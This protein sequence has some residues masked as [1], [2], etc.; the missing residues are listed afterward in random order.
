M[1]AYSTFIQRKETES[2]KIQIVLFAEGVGGVFSMT[3]PQS[4]AVL[5]IAERYIPLMTK[6]AT[7]KTLG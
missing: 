3:R 5:S 2:M 7:V 6:Q 4:V 1:R